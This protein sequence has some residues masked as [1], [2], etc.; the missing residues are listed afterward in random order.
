M[1]HMYC[2]HRVEYNMHSRRMIFLE[3]SAETQQLTN[4]IRD[5]EKQL[6]KDVVR[7]EDIQKK[8]SDIDA[9]IQRA[10]LDAEHKEN[11]KKELAKLQSAH[12]NTLTAI[13][14]ISE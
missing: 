5:K 4:T 8:V 12:A 6:K 11:V 10:P 1:R 9:K 13:D 2:H 7:E 3:G 14:K